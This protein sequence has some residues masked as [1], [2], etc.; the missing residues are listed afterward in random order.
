M[1]QGW[2]QGAPHDEV[3]LLPAVRRRSRLPRRALPGP[4]RHDGRDDGQRPARPRGARRGAR[5]RARRPAHG[6]RRGVAGERAAPARRRRARPRPD[7]HLGGRPAARRRRRAG[8]DQGRRRRRRRRHERRRGRACSPR[9]GPGRRRCWRAA[10]WPSPRRPTTRCPGSP[11]SSRGWP[12]SRSWS[13]PT[14]T[15]RCS[16][17][18]APARS[19]RRARAPRPSWPRPSRAALGHFTDVL[20][21]ALP[22]APVELLSGMPRRLDR[23]AG[24]GAAGGLGYGLLA[25]GARRVGGVAE[26][27]RECGFGIA[28]G[29]QRPRR[30]RR[31]AGRLEH[32]ARVRGRRGRRRHPRDRAADRARRGGVPRR[33]ARDDDPGPGR[34][35]RRRRQPGRGRG[36]GGRPGR[37]PWPP[38]PRGWRAPGHRR[39]DRHPN[40][41]LAR[42]GKVH[43]RKG[44]IPLRR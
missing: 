28:G 1:A 35:L 27:L 26:V 3:E 17:C 4:R 20:G 30:H 38:A 36:D 32:A 19:R 29:P 15:P 8:R 6:L 14:T 21:R 12:G 5:G 37:R 13:P 34:H 11:T 23:E 24:A 43:A 40:V 22:S 42:C 16:A 33:P 2:S 44:T 18:R 9:S 7:Q 10:G 41:F 31:R 25:L 39:A